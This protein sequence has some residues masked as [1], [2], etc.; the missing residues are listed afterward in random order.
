MIVVDCVQNTPA[1][2][3]ARLG[4]FTAS[5]MGKWLVAEKR[6]ARDEKAALKAIVDN[7]AEMGGLEMVPP[8]RNYILDRGH[9]LEPFARDAYVKLTGNEV[10]QVGFVLHDNGG[11]GCS[12]DAL[13][14][15]REGNLQI[16]CPFGPG[17][18]KSLLNPGLPDDYKIQVHMEMAVC[19]T[20]YNDY[21]SYCPGAASMLY[22]VERDKFTESVLSGLL[23]LNYEF[24]KYREKI[25]ALWHQE[26][27]RIDN[28]TKNDD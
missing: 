25:D 21:F 1:W 19:G 5:A 6:N 18:I 24:D 9:E 17:Q 27:E 4:V 12:P 14:N 11:F 2:Y 7:L 3:K 22:R 20:Q 16:K 28:Q 8:P 23:R 10:E 13:V 26:K 15:N